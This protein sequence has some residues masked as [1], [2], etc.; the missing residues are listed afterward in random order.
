[1]CSLRHSEYLLPE[2]LEVSA[3]RTRW[4]LVIANETRAPGAAA[5]SSSKRV[6][7]E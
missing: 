5:S 7:F 4:Y 1:M 6:Y 2:V 3:H